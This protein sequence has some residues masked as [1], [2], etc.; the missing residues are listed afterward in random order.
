VADVLEVLCTFFIAADKATHCNLNAFPCR[1]VVIGPSSEAAMAS[2]ALQPLQIAQGLQ[3]NETLRFQVCPFKDPHTVL[4][5]L[6]ALLH[7]LT[8]LWSRTWQG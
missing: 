6:S 8:N 5:L 3:V 1:S 7:V 4:R 2:P